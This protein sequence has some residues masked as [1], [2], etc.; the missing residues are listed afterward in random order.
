MTR[1][2][3]FDPESTWP[4]I[5]R[6]IAGGA[7]LTKALQRLH[8][9]PSYWWAKDQL[10]RD[11]ELRARYQEAVEDR[12]DRLAEELLELAD[13]EI[14]Q[15]LDGPARSAFVQQ[16]RLR[17]DARKWAAAKLRPRTY[18]DRVDVSVQETRISIHAALAE[19]EA[20]VL[21]GKAHRDDAMLSFEALARGR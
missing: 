13:S 5:L 19:A 11:S 6:D 3:I 7:S 21:S 20:R 17:V 8:P 2:I 15:D 12:A 1:P 10:R 9:S 16:L 4:K 18:G 14:P